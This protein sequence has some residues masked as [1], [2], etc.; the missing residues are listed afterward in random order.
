MI[1]AALGVPYPASPDKPP[2]PGREIGAAASFFYV[3]SKRD[4]FYISVV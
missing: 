4:V 3:G 2:R 1:G